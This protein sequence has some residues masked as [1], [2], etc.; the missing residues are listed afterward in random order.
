MP[1]KPKLPNVIKKL[2]NEMMEIDPLKRI[3]AENCLNL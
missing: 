2:L 3:S 1:V